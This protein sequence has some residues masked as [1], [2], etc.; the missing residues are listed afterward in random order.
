MDY[1]AL[2][3]NLSDNLQEQQIKLGAASG[4]THWFYPLSS[5]N[6][7][8]GVSLDEAGMAQAL[9][10]LSDAAEATLGPVAVSHANGRFCLTLTDRAGE[11]V[12]AHAPKDGFLSELVAVIGRHGATMDE[13]LAVFY[14]HADDVVTVPMQGKD[15]DVLAYFA[16]G[17]PDAYR[18]CL[19]DEGCHIIYHRFTAADYADFYPEEESNATV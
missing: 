17:R 6:R 3:D 10:G 19:T 16:G 8:L 1:T 11:F 18:Y 12:R 9:A 5:L 2:L 7:F 4:S 14:R 15:F 13:V